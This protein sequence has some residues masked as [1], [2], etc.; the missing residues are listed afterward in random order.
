MTFLLLIWFK[1]VEDVAVG[2][3]KDFHSDE[4]VMLNAEKKSLCSAYLR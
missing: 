4:E 1:A 3:L 2:C